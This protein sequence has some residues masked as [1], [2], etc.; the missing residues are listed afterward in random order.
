MLESPLEDATLGEGNR[1]TVRSWGTLQIQG[2]SRIRF[3]TTGA[4]AQGNACGVDVSQDLSRSKFIQPTYDW[5]VESKVL[6]LTG[7]DPPKTS[8]QFDQKGE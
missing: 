2:K 4:H 1:V 8:F 6:S 5:S 3:L 7:R